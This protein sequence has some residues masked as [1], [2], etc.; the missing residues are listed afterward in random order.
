MGQHE[1]RQKRRLH[2]SS[3]GDA[4]SAGLTQHGGGLRGISLIRRWTSHISQPPP[5]PPPHARCPANPPSLQISLAKRDRRGRPLKI[6]PKPNIGLDFV[7]VFVY[8]PH[9]N[10]QLP[11][12]AHHSTFSRTFLRFFPSNR[13]R[14]R[15]RERP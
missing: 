9:Y 3:V 2:H 8:D 12:C 7:H 4:L 14:K 5:P 11:N 15:E 13:G 10:S 6:K 1:M